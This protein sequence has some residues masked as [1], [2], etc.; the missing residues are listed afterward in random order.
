MN[1]NFSEGEG[2]TYGEYA[3]TSNENG[4][5][6]NYAESGFGEYQT[7]TN[8]IGM[9][10]EFSPSGGEL[11]STEEAQF[12]ASYDVLQATS[13]S[14]EAAQFGEYQATSAGNEFQVPEQVADTG[15]SLGDLQTTGA[16]FDVLQATSAAGDEGTQFGEYQ[17]T[18]TTKT[19]E[20]TSAEQ[21]LG[22]N[23]FT[24]S[25][26]IVGTQELDY[27]AYQTTNQVDNY[28]TSIGEGFDYNAYQATS[29]ADT[30]SNLQNLDEILHQSIEPEV[31]ANAEESTSP[32]LDTTPTFEANAFTQNEQFDINAYTQNEQ[33]DVNNTQNIDQKN[34]I[35]Y[36]RKIRIMKTVYFLTRTKQCQI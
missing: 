2:A 32:I 8:E 13:S 26:P 36:I 1:N 4:I 24:S 10:S 31:D 5:K 20:I 14:G 33:V 6:S 35:L 21:L 27:N 28:T 12:G 3:A 15:I 17:A 23:D 7:T 25:T 29:S 16:S 9:D 34:Y 19:D 18:T 22:P 11:Q 30:T